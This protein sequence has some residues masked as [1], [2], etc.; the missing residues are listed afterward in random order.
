LNWEITFL[1][2]PQPFF[3]VEGFALPHSLVHQPSNKYLKNNNHKSTRIKI[4]NKKN[5]AKEG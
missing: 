3:F 4:Y 5:E 2:D 1:F